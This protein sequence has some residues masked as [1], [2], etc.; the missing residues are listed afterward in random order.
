MRWDAVNALGALK[1]PRALPA[2][3]TRALYD[4]NPHPQWRAL[5]AISSVDPTGGEAITMFL[6]ALQSSDASLAHRAAVGLAFF[7]RPEAISV[8]VGSLESP[9]SYIR[10]EAVFSLR[11]ISSPDVARAVLPWLSPDVE[12]DDGVHGE[13]ALA[14]SRVGT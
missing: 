1:D 5:W 9:E 6:E 11:N 10:W 12:P 7:S 13:V 14:L 4:D 2:L 3:G 8:L